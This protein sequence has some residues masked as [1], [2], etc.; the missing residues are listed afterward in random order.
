MFIIPKSTWHHLWSSSLGSVSKK[1]EDLVCVTNWQ[2][3]KVSACFMIL[4]ESDICI[5]L[6]DHWGMEVEISPNTQIYSN[7]CR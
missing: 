4:L 2:V 5:H 1:P 6:K 7:E 3:S